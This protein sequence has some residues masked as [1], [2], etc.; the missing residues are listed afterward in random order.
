MGLF[1]GKKQA[2]TRQE[3][4][5]WCAQQY[6]RRAESVEAQELLLR[7]SRDYGLEPAEAMFEFLKTQWTPVV[8]ECG[9]HFAKQGFADMD[10]RDLFRDARAMTAAVRT[11]GP[12]MFP[13]QPEA[14]E[15]VVAV[16]AQVAASEGWRME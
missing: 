16:L 8:Q 4:I 9:Q 11:A 7:V 15:E 13:L 10:A 5:A 2:A 12:V 1:G 6:R 14:T 3:V